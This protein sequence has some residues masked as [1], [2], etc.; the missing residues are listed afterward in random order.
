MARRNRPEKRPV[1]PDM[2][3]QSGKVSMFIN[4]LMRDGKNCLKKLEK[5]IL[6]DCGIKS[7]D[8]SKMIKLEKLKHLNLSYNKI[9]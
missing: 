2:R 5:I 8:E 7:F 9:A 4:R 1:M 6:Y 3:Y